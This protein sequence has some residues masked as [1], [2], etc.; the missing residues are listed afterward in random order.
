MDKAMIGFGGMSAINI[1]LALILT[2]WKMLE[3]SVTLT[4]YTFVPISLDL[5]WDNIP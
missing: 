5:S 4:M 3:L 1:S 2:A